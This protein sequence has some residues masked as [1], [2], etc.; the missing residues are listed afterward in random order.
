[1]QLYFTEKKRIIK[2]FFFKGIKFYYEKKTF[3]NKI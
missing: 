2:E 1:M 3:Y